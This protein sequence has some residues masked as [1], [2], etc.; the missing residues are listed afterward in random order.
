MCLSV[1][2][3]A[4]Q[5]SRIRPRVLV[6]R[7][8]R[9]RAR[10]RAVGNDI[11]ALGI[12][13]LRARSARGS[14]LRAADHEV[15]VVVRD[16]CDECVS[17]VTTGGLSNVARTDKSKFPSSRKQENRIETNQI[18]DMNRVIRAF[19]LPR[20]MRA[21]DS[22][23]GRGNSDGSVRIVTDESSR[24]PF[25]V[26]STVARTPLRRKQKIL[27]AEKSFRF[28]AVI[29]SHSGD[30]CTVHSARRRS[31]RPMADGIFA[32]E[33]GVN[34]RVSNPTKRCM[35]RVISR[36]GHESFSL[37]NQRALIFGTR[38]KRVFDDRK[39]D[40]VLSMRGARA[41]GNSFFFCAKKGISDA[42]SI[43]RSAR[44]LR[45]DRDQN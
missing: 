2:S 12:I 19:C 8:V 44:R 38:K 23:F 40:E 11:V 16:Y 24:I 41:R 35:S 28:L 17:K 37:L 10:I 13:L 9:Q 43:Y 33:H 27:L 31:L 6:T 1:C 34:P 22:P 5:I 42:L 25:E 26:H 14:F 32:G 29:C 45:S 39:P 15:R 18:S 30:Q 7:V 4:L 36:A 3:S 20:F 21:P